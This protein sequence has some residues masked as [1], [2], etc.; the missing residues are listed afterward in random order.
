M[1]ALIWTL[2]IDAIPVYEIRPMGNFDLVIF[3]SLIEFLREFAEEIADNI[4]VAGRIMGSKRL[5]NGSVVPSVE[6]SLRGMSN[7]K[8][9]ALIDALIEVFGADPTKVRTLEGEGEDEIR[10]RLRNFLDRVYYEL[11]NLGQAPDDRAIN[12]LATNAFDAGEVFL[13]AATIKYE[14]DTIAAEQ[15]AICRPESLC[16]DVL[17]TF[18]DPEDRQKRARK[19]YRR[20]VDVSD[21]VPVN[22]GAL[23]SWYIY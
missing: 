4:S 9:A 13:D 3:L 22:V 23:R 16:Y 20:T 10:E 18:F 21:V 6:P 11:R 8:P 12:F 2:N 5:Y 17:L 1:N 19:Q 15:S 14:L 7:W